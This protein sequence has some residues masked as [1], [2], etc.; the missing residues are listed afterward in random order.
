MNVK[1]I[2]IL[3]ATACLMLTGCTS[4]VTSAD[5]IRA[6]RYLQY[7][8]VCEK[9]S[10]ITSE[11]LEN[12]HNQFQT[13]YDNYEQTMYHIVGESSYMNGI[14]YCFEEDKLVMLQNYSPMA[15]V[16]YQHQGEIGMNPI[17]LV[18][19]ALEG[20]GKS[21]TVYDNYT[22]SISCIETENYTSV[23]KAD[24]KLPEKLYSGSPENFIRSLFQP[25]YEDAE[26]FAVGHTED[27]TGRPDMYYVYLIDCR[28]DVECYAFYFYPDENGIFRQSAMD[29][30]IYGGEEL[31]SC[32]SS[33]SCFA[34]EPHDAEKCAV[35]EQ[36][37]AVSPSRELS[38]TYEDYQLYASGF[39]RDYISE[40][41]GKTACLKHVTYK[42]EAPQK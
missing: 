13:R 33:A 27:K 17:L 40:T 12:L 3:P 21:S 35:L 16:L 6:E 41:D 14:N 11:Q 2:M 39:S 9:V 37:L 15:S 28:E 29:Y 26:N 20:D 19:K 23:L 22:E 7:L 25:F 24:W 31:N 4:Q 32:L 8:P 34:G 18:R 38:G 42:L 10:G 1:K 5:R 36:I 30:L